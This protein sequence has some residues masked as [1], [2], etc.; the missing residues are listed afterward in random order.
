MKTFRIA[1]LSLLLAG[2]LQTSFAQA[3]K[4]ESFK[5]AG[6][7]GMCK[8]K[9]ESAAKSA[10]ATYAVWNVDSKELTVEFNTA[11]SNVAK[12][13]KNIASA[14][15]DNAGLKASDE[16]YNS[17]HDCCKYDRS[18]KSNIEKCKSD[19]C[20]KAP[21]SSTCCNDG[22]CTKQKACCENADHSSASCCKKS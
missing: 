21:A 8:K 5:V 2:F 11:S 13:Q 17:L 7:C 20:A 6:E 4:K 19:C 10:G 16:E 14:G 1:F 9:I 18:E 12:I 15:Y 3:N 22:K